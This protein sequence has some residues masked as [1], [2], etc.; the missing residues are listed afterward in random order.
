MKL[1]LVVQTPG[2][3]QGKVLESGTVAEIQ[4]SPE[5]QEIYLRRA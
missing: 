1:N 2:S 3:N 5:V 4:A